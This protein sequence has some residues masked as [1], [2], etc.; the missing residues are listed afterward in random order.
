MNEPL[1][2][3]GV[4]P[5]ARQMLAPG[6][7]VA[8]DQL[9]AVVLRLLG[10]LRV[11]PSLVIDEHLREPRVD[12]AVQAVEHFPVRVQQEQVLGVVAGNGVIPAV[13]HHDDRTVGPVA[14]LDG[15]AL[16]D[17]PA[18]FVVAERHVVLVKDGLQGTEKA[19]G[20]VPVILRGTV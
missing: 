7:Q 17:A 11:E 14:D 6:R 12:G 3:N 8:D 13:Q 19:G 15:V 16:V 10:Q 20:A 2:N 1:V 18:R 9:G 5:V 4:D